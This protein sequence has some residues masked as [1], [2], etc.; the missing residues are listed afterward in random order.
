MIPYPV[1]GGGA[2]HDINGLIKIGFLAEHQ[3][4]ALQVANPIAEPRLKR[5]TGLIQHIRRLIERDHPSARQ[6]LQHQRRQPP[7]ATASIEHRLVTPEGESIEDRPTPI[8]VRVGHPVVTGRVPFPDVRACAR[9]ASIRR[10][11]HHGF[12]IR[13]TFSLNVE[14]LPAAQYLSGMVR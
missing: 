8:D 1:K 5:N 10:R 12:S 13:G 6:P 9:A 11:I 7:R 2:E 4:I 14:G 3:Q